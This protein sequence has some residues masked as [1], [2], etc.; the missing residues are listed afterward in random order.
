MGTQQVMWVSTL[1]PAQVVALAPSGLMA[2]TTWDLENSLVQF[3]EPRGAYPIGADDD[4]AIDSEDARK[5]PASD[6]PPMTTRQQ[7]SQYLATR[8]YTTDADRLGSTISA[9]QQ[10]RDYLLASTL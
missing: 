8:V 4:E 5:D 3:V 2:F 9:R 10:R 6:L 1:A 7:I